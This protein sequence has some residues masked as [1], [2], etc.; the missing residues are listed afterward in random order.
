MFPGLG[1]SNYQQQIDWPG[2][3]RAGATF[4][5][6]L[7]TDGATFRSPDWQAQWNGAGAAGLVKFATHFWR[8]G[9]D[10]GEQVDNL[11]RALSDVGGIRLHDGILL[12]V[13]DASGA[14]GDV[15]ARLVSLLQ[16]FERD[17]GV[18]PLLY[19]SPAWIAA[20]LHPD[21]ALARYGLWIADWSSV[22]TPAVPAPWPFAAF[23]QD[24]DPASNIVCTGVFP[25]RE[26][27]LGEI[28]RLPLY[29]RL[30]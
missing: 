5:W 10:D 2:A 15:T 29:G 26:W 20:H 13:E 19:S 11:A 23:W 17:H 27:F 6:V 14:T 24:G 18:T 30:T 9:D 25:T 21:P 1:A 3:A 12:D 4:A 28:A 22:A 7:A 8:A 16:T